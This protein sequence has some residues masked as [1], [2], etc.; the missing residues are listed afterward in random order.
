MTLRSPR[1]ITFALLSAFLL[2]FPVPSMASPLEST[3]S[4]YK[5]TPLDLNLPSLGTVA[6][7]DLSPNDEYELGQEI[8]MEV[9][10]DPRYMT[11]PEISE[12]LNHLGF[13]LVSNAQS[14]TY[15]FFFFPMREPSLNAFAMPGGFIGVNTGTIVNAQNESELAGVMGHEIGHVSQRHIARMI[16]Q[17]RA[18]LPITIGSILL[19]ILAA[20]AGG[21]SGGDLA[22]AIALGGQAALIQRQLNYS[23]SA[24]RE[25][26]RVGLQTLYKSGFAPSGL[27]NFFRRLENN[28]RFTQMVA[29]SYLSTHPLTSERIADMDNRLRQMPT[30]MVSNSLAFKLI[31]FRAQVLQE[32][33]IAQWERLKS[34]WLARY[35]KAGNQEKPII[36]YGLS[37]V[38]AYLNQPQEAL[39]WAERSMSAGASDILTR[40][41][42]RAQFSLAKT[43]EA[44]TAAIKAAQKGMERYP[45]SVMMVN[46]VLDML[47]ATEQYSKV[48]QL[49]QHNDAFGTDSPEYHQWLARTYERL[50]KRSQQF[51]HTGVLLEMKGEKEAAAYQYEM[52][53]RQADADFYTMSN[54][55]ARLREVRAS[56]KNE[57]S[58]K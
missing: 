33:T 16:D 28:D 40:N 14:Y 13:K 25:A 42:T 30:R 4:A 47:F 9:R 58:K 24:E 6:G 34:A 56:L 15:R 39:R 26:D 20:R 37:V 52:A 8:M 1:L 49:T 35:D 31:Q 32:T 54:I 17:Q 46:N 3:G 27:R 29:P 55:D 44:Q 22:S 12:Y 45:L 19:A 36:A 57:K 48:I 11:D 51:L 5:P 50:G 43:R 41:L 7:S 10:K 38:S 23:Q 53:Q 2:E 21:N 18:N